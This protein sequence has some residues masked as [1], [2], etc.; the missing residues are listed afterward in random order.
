M[1]LFD[2]NP[3]QWHN[4]INT[5]A[6]EF[7]IELDSLKIDQLR[8][9]AIELLIANQA[10]NL[11]SIDNPIEIADTLMLDSIFPGKFILP[12][13]NVLDLGSGAGFPGIPLKVAYPNLLLT[14]LDSK[15][16]KIN[17]L[18]Q[19][20]RQLKLEGIR[21][22]QNRVEF[23]IGEQLIF[24]VVIS[25]AVTSLMNLVQLSAPILK[26][27]GLIIAMTGPEPSLDIKMKDFTSNKNKKYCSKFQP[28]LNFDLIH[29]QL[30]ISKKKHSLVLFRF[31]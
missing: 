16:K 11:T 7:E 28:P 17:F 27:P 26:K 19:I 20:I 22:I 31:D 14:L 23:M 5:G 29:Y 1:S 30:P 12:Y 18:K 15:R 10:F 6:S 2:I 25:R 8:L 4:W 3:T 13:S 9:Y 24:D 21:A